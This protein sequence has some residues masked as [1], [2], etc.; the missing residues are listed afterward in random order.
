MADIPNNSPAAGSVS[1]LL[2]DR[3]FTFIEVMIVVVILAVLAALIAPRIMGRTDDARRTATKVQIKNIEAA[4]QLYKLDNGMY[5]NSEQGL[6]ALV[7]KPTVGTIPKRWKIG[8]YLPKVPEDPWGN[9][10]RYR[11]PASRGD[12]EIVSLGADG[13]AGGEGMDGDIGNWNLD[14]D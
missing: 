14:N 4:L 3:G 6:K 9:P 13:E 1:A 10:Y 12:Y 5:P 11:S 7:E 2:S 8:G